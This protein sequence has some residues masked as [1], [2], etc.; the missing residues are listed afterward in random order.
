MRVAVPLVASLLV[1]LLSAA[2]PAH[3]WDQGDRQAYNN[4]MSL[5]K[6]LMDGAKDRASNNEDLETLCLMVIIGNDVTSQYV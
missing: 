2:V 5:L 3:A 4:K 1:S 6:V